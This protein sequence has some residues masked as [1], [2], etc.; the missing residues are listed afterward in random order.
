MNIIKHRTKKLILI[1]ISAAII[2]CVLAFYIFKQKK[3]TSDSDKQKY[4]E[5]LNTKE[6]DRFEKE[7]MPL[8]SSTKEVKKK[9][10]SV[11]IEDLVNLETWCEEV[12][13]QR[14]NVFTFFPTSES[15]F[16]SQLQKSLKE[17][18]HYLEACSMPRKSDNSI[19]WKKLDR[20]SREEYNENNK[21]LYTTDE[22]CKK[23]TFVI[24]VKAEK[25]KNIVLRFS[26]VKNLLELNQLTNE[27][28][29]LIILI[30]ILLTLRKQ[31][32]EEIG[33]ILDHQWKSEYV[34]I[35]K[36]TEVYQICL[37]SGLT[38]TQK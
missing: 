15:Q 4:L 35:K 21:D 38:L 28:V 33:K 7:I 18:Y 5:S 32:G 23:I 11:L 14:R 10:S 37:Q 16:T 22:H 9:Y 17:S 34:N 26:T 25:L 31:N 8:V 20:I 24:V 36:D 19:D 13:R 2:T 6:K 12:L 3:I 30:N 1:I 29:L 27:Y